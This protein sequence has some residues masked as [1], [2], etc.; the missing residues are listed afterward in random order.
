MSCLLPSACSSER[1]AQEP[2]GCVVGKG[3]L[4]KFETGGQRVRA[5]NPVSVDREQVQNKI[6]DVY[7]TSLRKKSK[8]SA[9][10]YPQCRRFSLPQL[11]ARRPAGKGGSHSPVVPSALDVRRPAL[12]GPAPPRTPPL[13]RGRFNA[14]TGVRG[15]VMMLSRG[16]RK[17][18]CEF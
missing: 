8:T 11:I 1:K 3:V 12:V 15:R 18:A 9:H 16:P 2:L 4:D 7:S 6:R 10:C 13:R 14:P 17:R 5:L